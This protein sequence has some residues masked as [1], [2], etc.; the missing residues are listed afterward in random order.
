MPVDT[1]QDVRLGASDVGREHER[2]AFDQGLALMEAAAATPA[3]RTKR[4]EAARYMQT[5]WGF[6]IRDLSH[7]AN[8]LSDG[9]KANLISIG[10]WVMRQTDKIIADESDD[11]DALIEINRTVREG[12]AT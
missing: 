1:Y 12:L 8:D 6:L 2:I 3:E 5:L 9:L 11:W 4:L 7:P 10:L